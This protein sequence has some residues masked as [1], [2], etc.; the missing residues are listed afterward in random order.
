[1]NIEFIRDKMQQKER[2]SWIK[3]I[4]NKKIDITLVNSSIINFGN[5]ACIKFYIEKIKKNLH[6]EKESI[7]IFL[8]NTLKL[9]KKILNKIKIVAKEKIRIIMDLLVI[10]CSRVLRI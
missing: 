2:D 8:K 4:I 9:K 6:R 10:D 1:M 5:L 7:K 3:F